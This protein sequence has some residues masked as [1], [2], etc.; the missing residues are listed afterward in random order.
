M[1]SRRP[2]AATTWSARPHSKVVAP[3]ELADEFTSKL[4]IS[5]RRTKS[6]ATGPAPLQTPE[7]RCLS[8]MRAVNASSQKLSTISDS[9]W[10][11][12]TQTL[13]KHARTPSSVSVGSVGDIVG[14]LRKD[15]Q[16]LRQLKPGEM[17]LERAALSAIGKL[18]SLEMVRNRLFP[19][20]EPC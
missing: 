4:A 14:S 3:D 17:D 11:T 13:P 6:K 12:S 8:A 1:L 5:K 9:G 15:L 2:T 16:L 18:A 20:P 10:K 19:S 7:E